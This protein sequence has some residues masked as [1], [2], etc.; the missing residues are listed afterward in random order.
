[1]QKSTAS[2]I[3]CCADAYERA[4]PDRTASSASRMM[5]S[6]RKSP[7]SR[8]MFV[9]V[10]RSMKREYPDH[11]AGEDDELQ[12]RHD[13]ALRREHLAHDHGRR[14]QERQLEQVRQTCPDQLR[15]GEV[16]RTE[17]HRREHRPEEDRDRPAPHHRLPAERLPPH[18]R[19]RHG[20]QQED[21]DGAVRLER[22]REGNRQGVSADRDEHHDRRHRGTASSSRRRRGRAMPCLRSS[23]RRSRWASSPRDAH[24]RVG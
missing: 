9:R 24:V 7:R 13:D 12:E 23:S 10:T 8:K 5:V 1:M 22:E 16:L 15:L 2:A 11:D 17:H 3:G 4:P 6:G 21:D 14:G 18:Q 19:H 20:D